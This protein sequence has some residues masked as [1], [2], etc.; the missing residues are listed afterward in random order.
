MVF[1]RSNLLSGSVQERKEGVSTVGL[2]TEVVEVAAVRQRQRPPAVA[3]LGAKARGRGASRRVAVKDTVDDL[4]AGEE[5]EALGWEGRSA[6]TEGGETPGKSRQL[7]EHALA[8]EDLPPSH[9][10]LV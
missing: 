4:G 8:E 5:T 9:G 6:G 7:V 3:E 1:L 2:A 10:A